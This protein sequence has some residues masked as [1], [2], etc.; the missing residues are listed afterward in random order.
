MSSSFCMSCNSSDSQ[1]SY[2]KYH[3]INIKRF[4]EDL[5]NISSVLSPASTV[6]DLYD[7]YIH[8]LGGCQYRLAPLMFGK[9]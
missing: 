7:Q 5:A 6:T 8:D 4:F 9:T 2:R 1:H 3:K